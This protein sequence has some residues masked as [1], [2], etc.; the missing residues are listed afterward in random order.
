MEPGCASRIAWESHLIA[1]R[2][3]LV[4]LQRR[5]NAVAFLSGRLTPRTQEPAGRFYWSKY[6]DCQATQTQPAGQA[7]YLHCGLA[8][9]T[10]QEFAKKST[11]TPPSLHRSPSGLQNEWTA[12]TLGVHARHRSECAPH[13]QR[14]SAGPR[15][16]CSRWPTRLCGPTAT[17]YPSRVSLPRTCDAGTRHRAA[18]RFLGHSAT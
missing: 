8:D 3:D 17:D 15:A 14:D 16:R 18:R 10:A 6:V 1:L 4:G 7:N 2:V 5:P 13:N 9:R 12:K 11:G